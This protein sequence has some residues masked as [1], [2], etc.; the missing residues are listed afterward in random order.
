MSARPQPTARTLVNRAKRVQMNYAA[1][2]E[3]RQ[4]MADGLLNLGLRIGLKAETEARREEHPE[5]DARLRAKRGAPMMAD[6]GF[7]QVWAAGKRVGGVWQTRPRGTT[8][9][10]D[11][12]VLFVGFRSPLSHF[13]E[14]GT[15]KE[16]AR[17]FLTPAVMSEVPNAER[18]VQAALVKW[19]ARGIRS[20]TSTAT[21][22]ARLTQSQD[23][24]VE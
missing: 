10:K 22:E 4:A 6:T 14:F 11:Q 12:A 3:M 19:A 5:E 13:R 24:G 20:G 18:D 17:P 15:V 7:V 16:I 2:D 21:I 8:V 9:P 23:F 1:L